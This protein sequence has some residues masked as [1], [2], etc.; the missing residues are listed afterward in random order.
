MIATVMYAIL[1]VVCGVTKKVKPTAATT[2]TYNIQHTTYN[3]TNIKGIVLH[4][5]INFR[6]C[7]QSVCLMTKRCTLFHLNNFLILCIFCLQ[8]KILQ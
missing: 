7:Q 8:E 3:N 5:I 2:T 6:L 4:G 1:V